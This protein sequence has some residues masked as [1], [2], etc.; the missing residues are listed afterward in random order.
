M[1]DQ[2]RAILRKSI[3]MHDGDDAPRRLLL[4][5]RQK[6]KLRYVFKS[7]MPADIKPNMIERSKITQSGLFSRIC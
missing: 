4:T 6:T 5:T 2:T 3:K 1:K 7:N